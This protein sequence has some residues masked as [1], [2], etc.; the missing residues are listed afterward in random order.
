MAGYSAHDH[1]VVL[2]INRYI[3]LVN[4][5][6]P[7][8][9]VAEKLELARAAN[10]AERES[11]AAASRSEVGRDVDYYFAAR[12]ELAASD[13]SAKKTAKAGIG[14]VATGVYNAIKG[15]S[16]VSEGV[17]GPPLIRTVPDRPNAPI[18][19]YD[20]MR[21]GTADGH[22]DKGSDTTDVKLH[23]VPK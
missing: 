2:R 3:E 13:S 8:S 10:I 21:R 7:G 23:S 11:S 22:L 12:K 14:I 16:T 1:A 6:Y 20:W 9:T 5:K 18:G 19:G 17:G 15:V 4:R